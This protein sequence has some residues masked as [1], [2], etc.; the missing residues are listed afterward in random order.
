M[1]GVARFYWFRLLGFRDRFSV[2]RMDD[3]DSAPAT[4]LDHGH[5]MQ[6]LLGSAWP[7]ALSITA[8]AAPPVTV[9]A[10]AG[11]GVQLAV[12]PVATP[13]ITGR[14]HADDGGGGHAGARSRRAAQ[15]RVSPPCWSR[16][17]RWWRRAWFRSSTARPRRTAGSA[18]AGWRPISRSIRRPM[19]IDWDVDALGSAWSDLGQLLGPVLGMVELS[20]DF[21]ARLRAGGASADARSAHPGRRQRL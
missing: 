10:D 8:R 6:Y 5:M 12:V 21:S 11:A 4:P 3:T 1:D 18:R 16:P 17:T 15:A 9:A 19:R 20:G 7:P 14:G 2:P 13:T